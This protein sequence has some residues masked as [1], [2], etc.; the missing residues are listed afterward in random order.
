MNPVVPEKGLVVDDPFSS[1]VFGAASGSV[2]DQARGKI[3]VPAMT[4]VEKSE[5]D[6]TKSVITWLKDQPNTYAWKVFSGSMGENGHPDVD[7]CSNGRSIKIEMKRPT[8]RP[9]SIQMAR[10][11]QWRETGAVVGWATSLDH[12]QQLVTYSIA[13]PDWR[14]PLTGPGVGA[15]ATPRP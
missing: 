10:L 6:I 12:V 2:A 7:G 4:R 14:N 8:K 1:T 11:R 13:H 5:S 9:T 15:P 3:I